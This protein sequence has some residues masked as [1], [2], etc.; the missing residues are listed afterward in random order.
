MAT[1]IKT[2][3]K[4]IVFGTWPKNTLT[5]E[6][7]KPILKNKEINNSTNIIAPAINAK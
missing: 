7:Y 2:T 4:L 5:A 3:T 1:T 6:S